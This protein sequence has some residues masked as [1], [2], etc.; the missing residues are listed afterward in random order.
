MNSTDVQVLSGG[1]STA[2]LDAGSNRWWQF[3][4]HLAGGPCCAQD[5]EVYEETLRFIGQQKSALG[6]AFEDRSVREQAVYRHGAAGAS[7]RQEK[8]RPATWMGL[9]RLLRAVGAV[10]ACFAPGAWRV[11]ASRGAGI[12]L[13]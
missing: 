3:R 12:R 7:E 2:D 6:A 4:G 10:A 8:G 1:C 9:S 5:D 11:V 13:G